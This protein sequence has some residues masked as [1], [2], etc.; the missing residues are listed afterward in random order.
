MVVLQ[1]I[2]MLLKQVMDLELLH[3]LHLHISLKQLLLVVVLEDRDLV[4]PLMVQVCLVVLV[5]VEVVMEVLDLTLQT[6]QEDHLLL[7]Q[8]QVLTIHLL[9]MEILVDMVVKMAAVVVVPVVLV[10]LKEVVQ[11]HQVDQVN[12]SL[13]L[14]LL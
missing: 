9:D 10:A 14:H 3:I 2:I 7:L 1:Q 6:N 4:V 12:H 11:Q 13:H 5:V 8:H